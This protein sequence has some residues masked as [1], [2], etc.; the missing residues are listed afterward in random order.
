MRN[1]IRDLRLARNMTQVDLSSLLGISQ[2][3]LSYWEN[4]KIDVDSESLI[5]LSAIFGCTTDYLLC[6][7]D[8]FYPESPDASL[9]FALFGGSA[10]EI[11]DEEF[12]EVKRFAAFIAERRKKQREDDGK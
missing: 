1:R 7:S 8:V 5:K 4:G 12:E 6:N 10:K 9:R 2:N 11:T 3:T